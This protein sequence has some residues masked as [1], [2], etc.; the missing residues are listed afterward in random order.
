VARLNRGRSVYSAAT[1]ALGVC[2]LTPAVA[3]ALIGLAA[4][5]CC[6]VAIAF[7]ATCPEFD[8]DG[9]EHRG[10]LLEG[11][12]ETGDFESVRGRE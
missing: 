12:E 8:G 10:S 6:I 2:I 4:N 3:L 11:E 5:V 9:G 1:I 7:F